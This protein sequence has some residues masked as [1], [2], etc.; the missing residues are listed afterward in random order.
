MSLLSAIPTMRLAKAVDGSR[1]GGVKRSGERQLYFLALLAALVGGAVGFAL[2]TFIAGSLAPVLAIS[3]FEG[4]SGYFAVFVGGPV[5]GLAGVV[6]G[7]WIVLR[8]AG[9]RSFSALAKRI[10]LIFVGV[11]GVGAAGLGG[12]WLSRPLVNANG[13]APRL[14]FEILLPP[15]V[16]P[17]ST[18]RAIQ[19]HTSKN[20]MPAILEAG[21][22]EGNRQVVKGSVEI[23]YRTWQR[24]LVLT[25][26]DKTDVLFELSLGLSPD[27]APTFGPWRQANYIARPGEEQPRRLTKEDQYD[28]RYRVVWA[29]ED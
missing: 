27:H 12:F 25:M 4:A 10:A 20:R 21:R 14:V 13:P 29:D 23:Y 8:R 16:E 7:A 11:L 3:D 1:L 19:L 15:N 6:L 24:M 26:P 5:G 9:H 22:L 17:V 28:I 2:G 18:G